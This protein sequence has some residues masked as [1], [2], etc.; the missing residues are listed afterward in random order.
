MQAREVPQ[1][2]IIDSITTNHKSHVSYSLFEIA[3]LEIL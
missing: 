3:A 1:V 2:A